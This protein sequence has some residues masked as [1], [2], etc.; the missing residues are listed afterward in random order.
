MKIDF[1]CH[2]SLSYD[3]FSSYE[4]LAKAAEIKEIDV[5][6]I[7]EHDRITAQR[8]MISHIEN[9]TFIKGCEYTTQNGAHV[10]GLFIDKELSK[11][12]NTYQDVFRHIKDH[13]GLIS[14]PHPFKPG[15]GLFS[16]ENNFE[17]L[18]LEDVDLIELYNGGYKESDIERNS[19]IQLAKKN[20][21]KVIGSS[22]AHKEVQLGYYVTSYDIESK[23]IKDLIKNYQGEILHDSSFKS[24]PRKIKKIQKNS[25]FIFFRNLIKFKYRMIIKRFFYFFK[26]KKIYS[27]MYIL[28]YSND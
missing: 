17:D 5:I 1:H 16:V 3:G 15:S 24:S 10:I 6:F 22:D 8:E 25:F 14:I 11:K 27:P 26:N 20:N 7:T 23:N 2:T 18:N 9:T 13:G 21:I 28:K 12:N 4:G 19:V